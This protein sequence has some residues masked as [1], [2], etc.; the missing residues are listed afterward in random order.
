MKKRQAKVAP[1]QIR[2]EIDAHYGKFGKPM[3]VPLP[4]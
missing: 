2:R 4:K 1:A 3:P